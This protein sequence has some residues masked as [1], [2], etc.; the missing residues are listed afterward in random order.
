MKFVV[1][2][3]SY[4]KN[5]DGVGLRIVEHIVDNNL[6]TGFEAIEAGNDPTRLLSC[7]E[8]GVERILIVDC[9]KMGLAPGEYK[10]FPLGNVSSVKDVGRS[11]THD[12]DVVQFVEM[13]EGFG[14]KP[15]RID[16]MGIE[17]ESLEMEMRLSETLAEK[18]PEYVKAVI[19]EIG[20]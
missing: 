3:G 20:R 12:G 11:S 2:M 10:I 18:M 4:A 15:P 6:D 16:F 8:E 7:L 14:S 19:E 17:P 1:G 9:A 5:D 13:V